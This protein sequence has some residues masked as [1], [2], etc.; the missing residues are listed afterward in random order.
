MAE[1]IDL[2]SIFLVYDSIVKWG[3]LEHFDP[4]SANTILPTNTMGSSGT[5]RTKLNKH[6]FLYQ[7]YG[8][9]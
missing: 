5:L 2:K 1:W 6:N 3:H 9:I 7:Y 8:V 4:N